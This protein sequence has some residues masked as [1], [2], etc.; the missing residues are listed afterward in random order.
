MAGLGS[1][2]MEDVD[3]VNIIY[4]CVQCQH[5]HIAPTVGGRRI[6][7]SLSTPS[8]PTDLFRARRGIITLE[9]MCR[10]VLQ[11]REAS[12]AKKQPTRRR[13]EPTESARVNSPV[14]EL[15][16]EALQR[17]NE[18]LETGRHIVTFKEGAV[19]EGLR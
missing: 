9:P 19:E 4:S 14:D 18:S 13:A 16:L 5:R 10:R 3:V 12:M 17:G 7:I 1:W 11:T 8:H 2:T 15:L 6:Y